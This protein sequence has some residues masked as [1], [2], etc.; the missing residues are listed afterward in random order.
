MSNNI[1]NNHHIFNVLCLQSLCLNIHHIETTKTLIM[2]NLNIMF[3][4]LKT[5]NL[6]IIFSKKY[7][8]IAE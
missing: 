4:L 8:V 2:A 7:A 1:F 6:K 3:F 5:T